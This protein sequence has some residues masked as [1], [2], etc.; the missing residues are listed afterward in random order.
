MPYNQLVLSGGGCKV[1][2]H[3]GIIL[4]L[5]QL[6]KMDMITRFSGSSMGGL[7]AFLLAINTPID[8]LYHA[9][10]LDNV[11]Q[12][13][14]ILGLDE[15][16]YHFTVKNIFSYL[17]SIINDNGILNSNNDKLIDW[18]NLQLMNNNLPINCTFLQ[19]FTLKKRELLITGSNLT[20]QQCYYFSHIHTPNMIIA[21]AITITICYP[22]LYKE[23][24]IYQTD[25]SNNSIPNN[26]PITRWL[27]GGYYENFP[28][29]CFDS[30]YLPNTTL[31]IY[32]ITNN[33]CP[34]YNKYLKNK[35]RTIGI[36]LTGVNTFTKLN[37]DIINYL[38]IKGYSYQIE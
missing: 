37:K 23:L 4:K 5:Q 30:Y 27:D 13:Y 16:Y 7:I 25:F 28:I 15:L 29:E 19:L 11:L 8:N 33:R 21:K 1:L 2:I 17:K 14:S 22:Y 3:L 6:N 26:L 38:I 34:E 9:L 36:Q 35:Y 24:T 12:L 31:G 20:T 10:L 18:I 32:F